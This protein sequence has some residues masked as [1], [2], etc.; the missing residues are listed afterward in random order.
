VL[1]DNVILNNK[2]A[3]Q[4]WNYYSVE[5]FYANFETDYMNRAV[6]AYFHFSKGKHFFMLGAPKVGLEYLRLASQIG[7]NDDMIHS[8]IAVFLIDYGFFE[9][10]R[11]ELEKALI[12]NDDLSGIHNNWGYYYY[13]SKNYKNAIASFRRAIN[14]NPKNHAYLN[15]LGFSLLE[16]GRKKEALAAFQKSLAINGDQVKIQ[17]IIKDHELQ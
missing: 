13:K 16:V 10:A 6:K 8:D 3:T 1:E 2:R 11:L 9:E 12:Y 4:I 15:N 14:L 5:S 7:Y 17:E